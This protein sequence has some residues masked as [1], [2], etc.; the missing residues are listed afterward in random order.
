[1]EVNVAITLGYELKPVRLYL[2]HL[3]F[4]SV[5][6]SRILQRI[7][8]VCQAFCKRQAEAKL[9]TVYITANR[10]FK[11]CNV[12]LAIYSNYIGI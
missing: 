9:G 5:D 7:D 8:Q 2:L 4:L 3:P 1:M 11:L 10:E 12:S 6:M